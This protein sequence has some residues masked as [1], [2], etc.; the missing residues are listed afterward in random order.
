MKDPKIVY[1]RPLPGGGYVHVEEEDGKASVHRGRVAVE[2]R[3]DPT[4]RDGHEP[5]IIAVAEGTEQN[6]IRQLLEIATDNVAIAR[7][8]LHQQAGGRARF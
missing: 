5:P 1:E 7:A 4:R 3:V 8:L 2:R 6:V